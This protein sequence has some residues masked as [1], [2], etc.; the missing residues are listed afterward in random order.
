MLLMSAVRG[1]KSIAKTALQQGQADLD[2]YRRRL[3]VCG[4]CEKRWVDEQN[5]SR[6]GVCNCYVIPKAQD[7]RERCP[8]FR[9]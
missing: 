2:T 8:I 3:D 4:R 5:R 9:W 1:A 6:C 7:A